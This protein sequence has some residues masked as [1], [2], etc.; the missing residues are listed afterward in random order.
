MKFHGAEISFR[1]GGFREWWR[2][3]RYLYTHWQVPRGKHGWC[4]CGVNVVSHLGLVNV[5]V[6]VQLRQL[7]MPY[8][9]YFIDV[10][11]LEDIYTLATAFFE[12]NNRA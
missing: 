8:A 1:M 5:Y 12:G 4:I 10:I 9:Y 7:L 11:M 3:D 6:V 2:L